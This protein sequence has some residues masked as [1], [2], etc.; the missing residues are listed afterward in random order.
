MDEWKEREMERW[1]ERNR[2][3]EREAVPGHGT[4]NV[5]WPGL[6]ISTQLTK[7]FISAGILLYPTNIQSTCTFDWE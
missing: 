6:M 7:S 3:R 2:E 1:G 4:I 5:K